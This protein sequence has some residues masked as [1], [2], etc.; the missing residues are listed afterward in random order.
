MWNRPIRFIAQHSTA[1]HST[2]QTNCVY[3]RLA[4]TRRFN[5]RSLSYAVSAFA[6]CV[7]LIRPVRAS[8][9]VAPT[10]V[11]ALYLSLYPYLVDE[12]RYYGKSGKK[13]R[14]HMGAPFLSFFLTIVFLVIWLRTKRLLSLSFFQ[15]KESIPTLIAGLVGMVGAIP[16]ISALLNAVHQ[17]KEYSI[18]YDHE[19]ILPEFVRS[20]R[21]SQ[22][23]MGINSLRD[24][25]LLFAVASVTITVCSLSSP[26]YP[27]NDCVDTNCF[28]TVGKS[29]LFGMVPYRDLYEQKGP[30]LYA[31]YSLCY[32]VSH[33]SFL[34]TWLLEIAAAYA[35][36]GLSW[37]C[38]KLLTGERNL[39][40]LLL[41]AVLVYTVPSFVKGGSAEELSLPLLM[42]PFYYGL[43]SLCFKRELTSRT[44]FLIGIC[45]GAVLW[46]KF[47]MLGFFLGFILVLA[48]LM[49]KQRHW[50]SMLKLFGSILFGVLVISLPIL[51]YFA[52]HH[53]LSYL[54]QAYFYNNIFVYGRTSSVAGGVRGLGSG[55]MSMLTFNDVTLLLFL[56][57]MIVLWKERQRIL[58]LHLFLC[59]GFAFLVIYIG[60]IN[61]QYY[62][63]ILCIFI[64]M[65]LTLVYRL[66]NGM[67]AWLAVS[68]PETT[69]NSSRDNSI[70]DIFHWTSKAVHY[71]EQN[72]IPNR[73][74]IAVKKI[75]I[76]FLF[77]L[78]LFGSENSGM[79]QHHRS[80]MPQF[81]FADVLK[82]Q[83]DTTLFNYG[84][85]DIGLY[86]T[87]DILP[88]TRYFCMLNLQSD[89]MFSEMDRYMETGA[90]EYIVSRG[91]TVES[92]CYNLIQTTCFPDG[93]TMYPYYLYQRKD[94][95]TS[96]QR[97]D[98]AEEI[99]K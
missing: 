26:I 4:L 87:A 17:F 79:L 47:S 60:G 52:Y 57:S 2:A 20:D 45:S 23:N 8:F 99:E 27:F 5:W 3:K 25:L 68:S 73:M 32:L 12:R 38:H 70:A 86:T 19:G 28:F 37:R 72:I 53:S 49:G 97:L 69:S 10:V 6:L 92:P 42:L 84:A 39:Y 61:L 83:P 46:I 55:L 43:R 14:I 50:I 93:D 40:H 76:P 77:L 85:L 64:P 88:S 24:K 1:Q 80:E 98:K 16:F 75:L 51:A 36:L 11:G 30:I 71:R 48:Y 7:L 21:E 89:E 44:G 35:F 94:M 67:R 74:N 82:D 13:R 90:T 78:A 31:L 58:A 96:M 34:G 65:G 22:V 81:I 95:S 15:W 66:F 63:E 9:V 56:F 18:S 29:A 33:R 91:L 59:F 62:S 41:T 54:W